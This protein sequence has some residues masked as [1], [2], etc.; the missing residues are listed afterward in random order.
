MKQLSTL[1]AAV[2]FAM[3]ADKPETSTGDPLPVVTRE[4]QALGE[5]V[6]GTPEARQL[7]QAQQAAK[8]LREQEE[9]LAKEENR[10]PRPT[11]TPE[12]IYA[13]V[14]PADDSPKLPNQGQ[15]QR[16]NGVYVPTVE[17]I[18]RAGYSDPESLRDRILKEAEDAAPKTPVPPGGPITEPNT[19]PPGTPGSTV[20]AET[21]APGQTLPAT[22]AG[23]G[24]VSE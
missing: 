10:E 11:P 15:G 21:P 16:I 4:R 14:K 13:T 3:V 22:D 5:I 8:T 6:P 24:V 18:T 9:K 1:H 17:E 20:G 19:P 12:E 23:P 7:W 2:L